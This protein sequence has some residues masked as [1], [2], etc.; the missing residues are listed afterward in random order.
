MDVFYS[1]TAVRLPGDLSRVQ[2][3]QQ[4]ILVLG[5]LY[6]NIAYL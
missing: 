5:K 4:N 3:E 1:K 2:F 6:I